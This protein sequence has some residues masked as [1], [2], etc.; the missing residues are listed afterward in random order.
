[1]YPTGHLNGKAGTDD[2]AFRTGLSEIN[3]HVSNETSS[4]FYL[5]RAGLQLNSLHA[6]QAGKYRQ[7]FFCTLLL[8]V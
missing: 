2:T 4:I 3:K 7:R 1:L 6:L 8:D 5:T